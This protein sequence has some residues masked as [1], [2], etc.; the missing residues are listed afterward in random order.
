M[1]FL[2]TLLMRWLNS[3]RSYLRIKGRARPGATSGGYELRACELVSRFI[4]SRSAFSK[5]NNRIRL[6]AFIPPPD[7]KLSVLHS[8][9]LQEQEI[10]ESARQTLRTQIGR[11][12][13]YGRADLVVRELIDRK[14]KAIRDD[15]PFE[16][17]TSVVGWPQNADPDQRKA[18]I[19]AL[20]L[21]LSQDTDT[22]VLILDSPIQNTP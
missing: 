10:W 11:E 5:E 21:E 16:R 3:L 22:R 6:G 2:Q 7:S 8:S 20:C 4:Y 19:K 15:D 14:L 18:D 1:E 17:H 12:K 9:G 13:V